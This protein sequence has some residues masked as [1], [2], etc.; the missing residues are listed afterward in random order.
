LKP[1][2]PFLEELLATLPGSIE[3]KYAADI[4]S[5]LM[6]TS[7]FKDLNEEDQRTLCQVLQTLDSI[8]ATTMAQLHFAPEE[9]AFFAPPVEI[10]RNKRKSK[11]WQADRE[12]YECVTAAHNARVAILNGDLVAALSYALDCAM[13]SRARFAEIGRSVRKSLPKKGSTKPKNPELARRDEWL[14]RRAREA[15]GRNP[16][17]DDAKL[18]R[19]IVGSRKKSDPQIGVVAT[20]RKALRRHRKLIRQGLPGQS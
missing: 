13:R 4:R 6:P 17:F 5:E 11:Q 16:D 15:L 12:D 14:V 18:A 7:H 9:L 8:A 19:L 3:S 10:G 2:P 1:W 20:V